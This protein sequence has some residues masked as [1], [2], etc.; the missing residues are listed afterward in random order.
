MNKE[1][2]LELVQEHLRQHHPDGI[3]LT[4]LDRGIRRE[5][6]FWHIPVRPS[7]QPERMFEYYDALAEVETELSLNNRLKFYPASWRARLPRPR[8][9]MKTLRLCGA[10]S[11]ANLGCG[12]A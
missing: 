1:R 6:G 4:A 2:V 8:K 11:T 12:P 5:D 7:G 3:T 9:C 10:L